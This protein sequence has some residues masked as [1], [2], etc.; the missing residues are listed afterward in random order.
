MKLWPA[1]F[2]VCVTCAL[3][4]EKSRDAKVAAALAEAEKFAAGGQWREALAA[5]N[6][7][8]TLTREQHGEA[9]P[10]SALA[11]L[12]LGEAQEHLGARGLAEAHFR[13]ALAIQEK[14]LRPDAPEFITTLTRLG[15]CLKDRQRYAEAGGLLQRA[16][17]LQWKI[18][19]S[20][21]PAT[22]IACTNL[23][24]VHRLQRDYPRAVPLLERALAIQRRAFGG[25]APETIAG[26][27]ELAQVAELAGNLAAAELATAERVVAVE[28][29]SG[30]HSAELASALSEWGRF[31]EGLGRLADALPRYRRELA[32]FET[33]FADDDPALAASR[34]QLGWC[35]RNL[36]RYDEA[37][38]LLQ[39]ALD[40][41]LRRLGPEHLDT[42]WSYR[43]L[44]WILRL[45]RD[46]EAARPMFERALAIRRQTLGE[47]DPLT[48]ESLSELGDLHWL[49]GAYDEAATLL[50]TR[51]YRIEEASGPASEATAA[52]WH[53][54][55]IV[56]E[57]AQR[58]PE[59]TQ[60]ALRSLKLTEARL[61]PASAPTL[62]EIVLLARI[63]QAGGAFEPA[64]TQLARLAAWFG[65][66]PEADGRR[67]AELLR[68]YAIT[69][70]RAGRA[71][72]AGPLFL[73]SRRVHET[74]LGP[75]DPATL[76][77]IGDLWTYYDETRQSALALKVARELAARTEGALGIDAPASVAIFDRLGQ[78]CLT[79][80]ERAEAM[81][82]FRRALDGR[83]RQFGDGST[84]VL[85]ALVR[86]AGWFEERRDFVTVANL[87]TERLGVVERKFG[88]ESLPAAA[89]CGDLGQCYFRQ[90]DFAAA[91]GMFEHQLALLEKSALPDRVAALTV[92]ARIGDVAMAARAWSAALSARERLVAGCAREFGPD[93]VEHGRALLLLG[94]ARLA[95]G[96]GEADESLRRA[97]GLLRAA[98]AA[99]ASVVARAASG[100]A[101]AA[102]RRGDA[103]EAKRW[104]RDALGGSL[105]SDEPLAE[106]FSLLGEE[107]ARAGD[108]ASAESALTRALT[109]LT[110]VAGDQDEHTITLLE[111]VALL[112]LGSSRPGAV[113]LLE[114]ALAASEAINGA[115]TAATVQLLGWLALARVAEGSA[116]AAREAAR[117][118][119]ET[120]RHTAGEHDPRF[121]LAREVEA[122]TIFSTG[123]NDPRG[124][125]VSLLGAGVWK[126]FGWMP[127]VSDCVVGAFAAAGELARP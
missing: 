101:R 6:R 118:M 27:L 117:R 26:L 10:D 21:D 116:T 60:A 94:E 80:G 106:A 39:L 66:H 72:A 108:A 73:D 112:R 99:Q 4:A 85:D 105:A 42:A 89:V 114:R 47:T 37:Q 107:L 100:L 12:F 54:L 88:A 38:P 119:V 90:R 28:A 122:W 18:G 77:S 102:L 11:E 62:G 97:E 53:G 111:R 43:N 48:I 2:L 81:R 113:P 49:R 24:R 104:T 87:Q 36:E 51:R 98:G 20:A 59:A 25:M 84:E 8:R 83:R 123:I 92:V 5:G 45:Q 58:W 57:S 1:L 55:A 70:L 17:D 82:W 16:L 44:G 40:A 91:R 120:L 46:F 35:L 124:A 74:A 64:L 93:H 52:A 56:Y 125:A 19:G 109:I 23:A 127:T 50:E 34:T 30:P 67:R 9:H 115:E 15:A 76:R 96:R 7:L 13:R 126:R 3:G 68:Q 71:D 14:V 31:A 65:Q 103:E 63:C 33:I 61:G 75:T 69:A 29:R 110:Q 95:S 79:L 32:I 41:R 78:L 22:A 86:F 121:T